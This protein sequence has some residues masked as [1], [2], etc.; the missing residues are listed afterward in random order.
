MENARLTSQLDDSRAENQALLDVGDPIDLTMGSDEEDSSGSLAA[1]RSE[2]DRAN[3]DLHS[4]RKQNSD[5]VAQNAQILDSFN[6]CTCGKR[7]TDSFNDVKCAS[8]RNPEEGSD[9]DV[10]DESQKAEAV[11]GKKECAK[12]AGEF[13]PRQAAYRYCRDCHQQ[14]LGQRKARSKKQARPRS[15]ASIASNRPPRATKAVAE[16]APPLPADGGG[17]GRQ[18]NRRRQQ[19]QFERP[20]LQLRPRGVARRNDT[21]TGRGQSRVMGHA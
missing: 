6:L 9:S 18:R 7:I 5:L 8:C 3:V 17:P 12:C 16:V 21:G 14:H 10:A 19:Q 11:T 1:L 20:L 4:L 13:R 2:L 15:Q